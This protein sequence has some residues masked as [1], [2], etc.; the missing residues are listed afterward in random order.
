MKT[1]RW[2]YV[3]PGLL[4]VFALFLSIF[5]ASAP[6]L[7]QRD[8][9][10]SLRGAQI[11]RK[12]PNGRLTRPSAHP[13]RS[14]DSIRVRFHDEDNAPNRPAKGTGDGAQQL[15]K[16]HLI[17]AKDAKDTPTEPVTQI[18]TVAELMR[19]GVPAL[20]RTHTQKKL[21]IQ[22]YKLADPA[23]REEALTQL[24]KMPE[25]RYAEPVQRIRPLIAPPN[26]TFY[27]M[28]ET[29]SEF[30]LF[31]ENAWPIQWP[32]QFIQ[33]QA[34]WGVWPN[35]YYTAA[36]KKLAP[37]VKIAVIDTGIDY[38]H[39][40]FANAGGVAGNGTVAADIVNGGQINLA[41][42][43]NFNA[44]TTDPF[45]YVGH[46]T[47]VSGIA[48]A[49]TNNGKG[50]AAIGYPSQ[51]LSLNV[52]DASANG[53]D[54]DVIDAMIWAADHGAVIASMSLAADGGYSQ[55]LQD[56]VNYCWSKN[57]LVVAAAGNDGVDYV[58]RY[59]GACNKVLCVS[60][61]MYADANSLLPEGL[62][63]YSTHG[64]QVGIGAP[65]GDA[66]YWFTNIPELGPFLTTELYTL[67][68][69]TTPTN[70]GTLTAP[71]YEY[72]QGT[73]MATPHVAGLAGLYAGAK[74]I[75]QTT[76]NAPQKIVKGIQRGAD[77]LSGRI[78]GG[79][80]FT[81]GYGRINAYA[82][83]RDAYGDFRNFDDVNPNTP[84]GV[85]G[86]VTYYGTPILNASLKLTAAG[87]KNYTANSKDDGTFRI[88]NVRAG[89]YTVTCKW[90]NVSQ[91]KTVVVDFGYDTMAMDFALEV[92]STIG[93]T[94]NPKS[95]TVNWG[96]NYTFGATVT[97]SGN[98][99][100]MWSIISGP[101]SIDSAGKYTAPAS[102]ANATT[103]VIMA[104]SAADT[105]KS[106]TATVYLPPTPKTLTFSPN[107]VLG[108]NSS[109]A[110]LTLTD[111]AP[112]GGATVNL[113]SANTGVVTVPATVNVAAGASSATF[114]A[115]TSSVSSNTNVNITATYGGIS[116]IS[117]LTVTASVSATIRLN[118]GGPAFNASGGRAFIADA[119]F[120]GGS[121]LTR[122]VTI[123]GTG[124]QA[125]YQ[126]MRYAPTFSYSIPVPNGTYTV[127][128]HFAET[129]ATFSGVGRRKF[130]VTINGATAYSNLDVF[131]DAGSGNAAVV[132]TG[133]VTVTNGKVDI[134][135]S[136]IVGTNAF[137]NAIEVY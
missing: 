75:S 78:D 20:Q 134:G 104:V 1:L 69:S 85:T 109:T 25:V 133:T 91:T 112:A 2:G 66:T 92:G 36:Q 23:K 58:R 40:D 64:L 76:P 136:T 81:M 45:D 52:F 19:R 107:P 96:G 110:T 35:K 89:T 127:K 98:T 80:S 68:Y 108:G 83:I 63:S 90:Q 62:A 11:P 34:A 51:V 74:G 7:A 16:V 38:E 93:V 121:S 94:I 15:Q 18:V 116:L 43:Y 87:R 10:P 131:A 41:E 79:W 119:Y 123:T 100:V 99:G 95:A 117:P 72:Q 9:P 54:V 17:D 60:A 48:A 61:T 53:D 33:A 46:G 129:S 77:N 24:R 6:S 37:G 12:M 14:L 137:I 3:T 55:G 44:G 126:T 13:F 105:T 115:T 97:G 30:V 128:L 4:G 106:D 65:G 101:G 39:E 32:L 73:S 124:D 56:A 118:S 27:A 120:V 50:V 26:D 122:N 8:L 71:M 42:S 84:G 111:P 70:G 102:G 88:P 49:A 125:L 31:P 5:G 86:Q 132:K 57:T 59:P 47:H 114:T 22:V 82:T 135:F 67:V 113:T 103:A 21:G 28:I 29:R 130:N